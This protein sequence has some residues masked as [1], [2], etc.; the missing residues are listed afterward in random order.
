M[1]AVGDKEIGA[2]AVSV[3]SRKEGEM[4][5][6]PVEEFV[7]KVKQEVDTFAK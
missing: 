1:L 7:Q 4:G 3:R 6:M 5:Q 2:E